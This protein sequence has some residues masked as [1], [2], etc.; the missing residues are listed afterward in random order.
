MELHDKGG[1][2]IRFR[3]YENK[4]YSLTQDIE[5]MSNIIRDKNITLEDLRVHLSQ[6]ETSIRE[7]SIYEEEIVRMKDMLEYKMNEVDDWKTKCSKL[8][9]VLSDFRSAQAKL[10]DY[11]GKIIMF[12]NEIEKIGESNKRK[13]MD[14]ENWRVK[15]SRME[16]KM[17]DQDAL[18]QEIIRFIIHFKKLAIKLKIIIIKI[19]KINYLLN[20]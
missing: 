15:C 13:A 8:E 5:E 12:R 14:V 2:N 17:R 7:S 11:E 16:A 10:K 20:K 19:I 3:E 4:I 9:L 6:A 1:L 18:E